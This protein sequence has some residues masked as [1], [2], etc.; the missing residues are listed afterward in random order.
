MRQFILNLILGSH[1]DRIHSFPFEIGLSFEEHDFAAYPKVGLIS[2][3]TGDCFAVDLVQHK[4]LVDLF[5]VNDWFLVLTD[6]FRHTILDG[7]FQFFQMV[8]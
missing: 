5:E 4:P 6:L 2:I 1:A 7:K 8:G 3:L